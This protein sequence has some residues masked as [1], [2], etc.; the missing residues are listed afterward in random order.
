VKAKIV[1]MRKEIQ[2][3]SITMIAFRLAG[4]IWPGL[5]QN[6]KIYKCPDSKDARRVSHAGKH[7][8]KIKS[9]SGRTQQKQRH[10]SKRNYP[11]RSSIRIKR[12]H[13]SEQELKIMEQL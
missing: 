9:W 7:S 2:G 6:R 4:M 1:K 8:V 5:T 12:I 10:Y 3:A 11:K 13:Y